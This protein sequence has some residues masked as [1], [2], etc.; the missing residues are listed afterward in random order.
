[1]SETTFL[2]MMAGALAVPAI[3]FAVV[4]LWYDFNDRLPTRRNRK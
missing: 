4:M 3:T 1:M 2:V